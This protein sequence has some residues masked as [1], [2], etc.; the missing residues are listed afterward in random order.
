MTSHTL[1]FLTSR[2]FWTGGSLLIGAGLVSFALRGPGGQGIPLLGVIGPTNP[3]W[4]V[5]ELKYL[6]QRVWR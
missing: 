2:A 5:Q 1:H 3:R 6:E 4:R